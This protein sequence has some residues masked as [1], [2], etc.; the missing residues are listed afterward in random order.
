[1][2]KWLSS[3][4]I[5]YQF[6]STGKLEKKKWMKIEYFLNL[7]VVEVVLKVLFLWSW[8]WTSDRVALA[9]EEEEEGVVLIVIRGIRWKCEWRFEINLEE[10]KSKEVKA[11]LWDIMTLFAANAIVIML[12]VMSFGTRMRVWERRNGWRNILKHERGSKK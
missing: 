1:M 5:V 10:G 9:M 6:S 4:S 11:V 12:S 8:S 2:I 7:L 3:S